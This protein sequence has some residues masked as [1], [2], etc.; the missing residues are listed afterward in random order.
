MAKKHFEVYS[1]IQNIFGHTE[2]V[3]WW[4]GSWTS[5]IKERKI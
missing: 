1:E 4:F 5:R 2:I 3:I